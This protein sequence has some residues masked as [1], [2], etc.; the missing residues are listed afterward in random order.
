M[1]GIHCSIVTPANRVFDEAA[2]YVTF[3]AWDG[4]QGVQHGSSP[5]LTRLG[6]GVVRIDRVSGGSVR[7]A[8]SGGFAQMQGAQLRLLADEAVETGAIDTSAA[9]R[10]LAEA[11]A[12]AVASHEH[13]LTLEQREG[14]ERRQRWA[15]ARIAAGRG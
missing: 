14:I 5:F 2:T 9:E 3:E 11:N 7:Y 1:A 15:R 6:A 4:Q 10:D 12:Q 8:L 13:A